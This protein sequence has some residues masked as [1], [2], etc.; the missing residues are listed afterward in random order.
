MLLARK[1]QKPHARFFAL[2]E[3]TNH[4]AATVMTIAGHCSRSSIQLVLDAEH[5][6]DALDNPARLRGHLALDRADLLLDLARD[7]AGDLADDAALLGRRLLRD[8]LA[9]GGDLRGVGDALRRHV[10]LSSGR[11]CLRRRRLVLV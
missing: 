3:A 10:G 7:R 1:N 5:R 9:S 11:L 2:R 6:L 4:A 8:R